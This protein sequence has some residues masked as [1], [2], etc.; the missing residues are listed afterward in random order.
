M[1]KTKQTRKHMRGFLSNKQGTPGQPYRRCLNI[2]YTA[3]R[4]L[5]LEDGRLIHP[6]SGERSLFPFNM[7]YLHPTKGRRSRRAPVPRDQSMKPA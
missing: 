6:D 4:S 5:A 2:E 3:P 1:A 7:T